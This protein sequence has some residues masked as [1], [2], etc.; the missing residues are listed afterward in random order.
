[1]SQRMHYVEDQET[2]VFST[3][4][5]AVQEGSERITELEK[6]LAE[7]EEKRTK[8]LKELEEVRLTAAKWAEQAQ[9]L[10]E[11][12]GKDRGEE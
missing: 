6:R 2:E 11:R 10:K 7:N 3:S 5:G 1:M 4:E 12:Y 8:L 9:K